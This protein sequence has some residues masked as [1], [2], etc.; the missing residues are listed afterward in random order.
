MAIKLLK[1]HYDEIVIGGNLNA[2]SYSY[3]ND[4]PIIINKSEPPHRFEVCD[5]KSSLA[6]W[7]KLFFVLSLKGLNLVGNKS[8]SVRI[9][10]EEIVVSTKDARVVKFT[11]KKITVFDNENTTGLPPIKEENDQFIVL[12]W[13]TAYS[14]ELHSHNYIKTDDNLVNEIYFYPTERMDGNHSK[15]KDMVALSHLS[16]KQLEDFEYSDTYVKFKTKSILKNLG[17]RGIKCG[18]GKRRALLLEIEKREIRKKKMD[19]YENAPNIKFQYKA[20][21]EI[22]YDLFLE[23]K[24][25]KPAS[26]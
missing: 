22:N 17:L 7:N 10:D 6:L 12:D 11:Y 24:W 4:T 26:S 18:G 14:C 23:D 5:S 25:L 19:F 16:K 21:K 8:N 9:K 3:L 20:P 15:I 13:I 1:Y 2:L